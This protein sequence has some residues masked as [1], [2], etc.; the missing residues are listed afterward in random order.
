VPTSLR[1]FAIYYDNGSTFDSED[2][3]F[4]SAPSDGVICIVRK[5]GDRTEFVS[6]GDYYVRFEEDGSIVATSDIGPLLRQLAPWLKF[7]RFT[8]HRNQERIMNRAR[9][10]WKGK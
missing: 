8:S 6:G 5:D 2:G 3:P 1:T 9:D 4:E 7:G 10:E